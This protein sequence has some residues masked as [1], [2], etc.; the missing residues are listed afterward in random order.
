VWTH[1]VLYSFCALS[2]CTDDGHWP[3]AGLIMDT[4]G[5]LYGTTGVGGVPGG[6]TAFKLIPNKAKT[7]WT[8]EVLYG[9]CAQGGFNCTD[10]ANPMAGLIK[11]AAGRLYGT[12]AHGGAHNN[13]GTAFEL[14]PNAAK[15]VWTEK[16]LYSFCAQVKC[17]DGAIPQAGLIMGPAGKLYG[18]TVLGGA[19]ESGTAFELTP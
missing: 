3:F 2:N 19:H 13:S 16:V 1:K 15:T 4:R 11:D 7:V 5:N 8:H 17:A 10:G 14:T 9:F 6:G 12:T 18:T